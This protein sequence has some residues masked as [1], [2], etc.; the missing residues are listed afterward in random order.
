MT[1]WIWFNGQIV[2]T[3][4]VKISVEDRGFQFADGV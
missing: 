4:Q 3:Q 2:T 1:E